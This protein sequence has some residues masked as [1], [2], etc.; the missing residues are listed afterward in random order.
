MAGAPL[1]KALLSVFI[2]VCL[3]VQIATNTGLPYLPV[4]QPIAGALG[5]SAKLSQACAF[6][7]WVGTYFGWYAGLLGTWRMFSPIDRDQRRFEI[8]A[9]R[10]G[11]S[12]VLITPNQPPRSF[13]ERHMLDFREHKF[14]LNLN[15]DPPA[16]EG[17]ARY[18]CAEFGLDERDRIVFTNVSRKIH[19]PRSPIAFESPVDPKEERYV[20]GEAACPSP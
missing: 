13:L 11:A 15:Y 19:P 12:T 14:L 1:K 6:T 5:S 7:E 20:L 9:V 17:Y 2:V 4:C 18:L 16:R 3:W 10:D 8:A